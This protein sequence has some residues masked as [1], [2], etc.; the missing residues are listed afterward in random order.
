MCQPPFAPQ[1]DS[2][3]TL[4][5][6]PDTPREKMRS[7]MVMLLKWLHPDAG[8]DE[9]RSVLA[10]RVT[11]AWNNVKTEERRAVYDADRPEVAAR[12]LLRQAA[13]MRKTR[14]GQQRRQMIARPYLKRSEA[15]PA[16]ADGS[17][18]ERPSSAKAAPSGLLAL[19]LGF[20][21]IKLR[22]V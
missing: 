13:T 19:L 2:Y 4:G 20:F 9:A 7:H 22:R 12:A 17:V 5:A 10:V 21:H 14:Q 8:P 11:K 1:A 3:R 16:E 18:P 6:T 15:S